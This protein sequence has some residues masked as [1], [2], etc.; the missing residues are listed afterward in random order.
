MV[1]AGACCGVRGALSGSWAAWWHGSASE[2]VGTVTVTV[3]LGT[4]APGPGS[5]VRVR[6]R[7]LVRL[8]YLPRRQV[9]GDPE[10]ARGAWRTRG[11][12]MART[13]FDRALQTQSL[14]GRTAMRRWRRFSNA[15]GATAA[16]RRWLSCRTAPFRRPS[17]SSRRRYGA[18]A[19]PR[20]RRASA[21]GPVVAV[22]A[23][24][25]GGGCGWPIEV[26]GVAV[27]LGSG[28]VAADRERQ[29]ALVTDGWTVLRYTPAQIRGRLP[30][31]SPKS[32]SPLRSRG[33]SAPLSG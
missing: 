13:S 33:S 8:G 23:G 26:D 31:S 21:S 10:T 19:C 5:D 20:S 11:S 25:R 2:P 24:L 32:A 18:P 12:R 17:G 16:G 3:P 9:P 1:R 30:G 6:R 29:N 27:P 15:A 22:L 4:P 14:A 28:G 7:D